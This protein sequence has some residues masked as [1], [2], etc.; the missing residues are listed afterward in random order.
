MLRK[1]MV[2]FALFLMVIPANSA[3]LK[4]EFGSRFWC[5]SGGCK[6][7]KSKVWNLIDVE[8]SRLSRC[9]NNG[10]DHYPII[11]DPSGLFVNIIVPGR[12]MFVKLTRD[13]SEYAEM[14]TM[15]MSFQLSFGSCK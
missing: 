1:I 4:C 7:S 15:G 13:A 5:D 12:S 3:E 10:C 9:D 6:T 14:V 2:V 8:R 11:S